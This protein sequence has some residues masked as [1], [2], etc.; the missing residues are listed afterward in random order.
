[1]YFHQR[2]TH[3]TIQQHRR[4]SSPLHCFVLIFLVGLTLIQ[5][6]IAERKHRTER[7]SQSTLSINRLRWYTTYTTIPTPEIGEEA[8]F[9]CLLP[10]CVNL[11]LRYL[12]FSANLPRRETRFTAMLLDTRTRSTNLIES[13]DLFTSPIPTQPRLLLFWFTDNRCFGINPT[14]SN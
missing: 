10:A 1:M 3:S 14:K 13:F 11:E 7:S 2:Q 12:F 4:R 5:E 6:E 8:F 9:G